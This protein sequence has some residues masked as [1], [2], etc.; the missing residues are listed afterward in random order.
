MIAKYNRF[1]YLGLTTLYPRSSYHISLSQYQLRSQEQ[2]K[3]LNH[4]HSLAKYGNALNRRYIA[5]PTYQIKYQVN[6]T[7]VQ[8]LCK[9]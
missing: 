1:L 9:R 7:V 8:I 4:R 2:V 3:H 6:I 5:M